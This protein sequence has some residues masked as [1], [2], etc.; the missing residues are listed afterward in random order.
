MDCIYI[1]LN[2]NLTY[3]IYTHIFPTPLTHKL[4]WTTNEGRGGGTISKPAHGAP[5]PLKGIWWRDGVHVRADAFYVLP[6]QPYN[7]SVLSPNA[8]DP[9]WIPPSGGS[10]TEW[11]DSRRPM[12][13]LHAFYVC[14]QLGMDMPITY[15][16]YICATKKNPPLPPLRHH[17]TV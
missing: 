12:L 1:G 14:Q 17:Q 13:I 16:L 4:V 15:I 7:P 11:M 3:I 9:Q 2:R 8:L 10:R 6:P 5:Y